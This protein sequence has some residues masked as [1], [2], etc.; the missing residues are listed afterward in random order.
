MSYLTAQPN[1]INP[2]AAMRLRSIPCAISQASVALLMAL[3]LMAYAAPEEIQ[4]YLDEFAETGKFGLDLHTIYVATTRNDKQ[5]P[6]HQLRVT[7]ELSYGVNDHLEVAAYFLS[8]RS[9]GSNPQTDGVKLR[10]RWR[11]IVPSEQTTW[12][13]A[14]NIELGQLSRRFNAD[15][16]NGEIKGILSWKSIRWRG[17]LNLN[18]D[19]PLNRAAIGPSTLELD[20]KLAYQ[21]RDDLRFGIEHY[22]FL[23]PIHG[24]T[25]TAAPTRSTFLVTDFSVAKW[26]I[27]FGIG[28]ARGAVPDKLIVK[29][30]IGVPI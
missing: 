14:V 7:P 30:I 5:L 29:A 23:G 10:M 3:P 27:Q 9:P 13:T 20:G 15:G 17:G 22:A 18:I 1:P 6:Y 2:Y 8:N 24:S 25:A 11:P 21:V 12:Y 19:R 4:V 28:Q 16:L 26:D